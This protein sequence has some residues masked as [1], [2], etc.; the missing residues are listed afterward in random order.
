[1]YERFKEKFPADFAPQPHAASVSVAVHEPYLKELFTQ[2]GG[3]SFGSGLYRVMSAETAASWEALVSS[4]FPSFAGNIACF[5]FDWL[6]RIFALDSKRSELGLPGVVML[7]PGTGQALEI[8]CNVHN[9]H[10]NELIDYRE[11]ALA[12]SFYAKWI[13]VG[14][15]VPTLSECI[16]Y[17]KPLFLGGK[18]VIENLERSDME[19]YWSI[20]SQ[21]IAKTR[22]L[23]AGTRIGSTHIE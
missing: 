7:E 17:K 23:P 9:F 8:P 15:V 6:G 14:G 16:G 19:V 5:G 2:F 18:D 12:A 21:L 11:E 20:A 3:G 13:S 4:A 22:G 1:M 10:E